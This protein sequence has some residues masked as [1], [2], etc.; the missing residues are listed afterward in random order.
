MAIPF[1]RSFPFDYGAPARLSGLVRRV[2]ARNPGPF[3]FTGTGVYLIGGADGVA[4]IDPGPDLPEHRAALLEALA[5]QTVCAVL[6]THLHLDHS[7]L[8]RPLADHFGAPLYG[9]PYATAPQ[10]ADVTME[11]GEDAAFR[12]D[13]VIADGQRVTGPDWT[14]RAFFTPGHTSNHVCYLLE[15]ENA[16]F[17]GDHVMGWST[18]VVSPPDGDMDAYLTSLDAV[19]AAGFDRLYPTHGAPI[20]EPAPFLAAYRA[21][22][23]AREA[24][25]LA[26][27]EAGDRTIPEM[28]RILYADVNPGLHPAAC[29]SV[30]AHMIALERRGAVRAE[31]PAGV[32][33]GWTL[34]GG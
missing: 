23:M 28:V 17:S 14:L 6:V 7:P 30:L 12:P 11:E 20:E 15:E 24:Q 22:R 4:I 32:G 33:A 1:I 21:H 25:I 3:T 5:G 9:L 26:R 31:G 18:T 10:A 8:A 2:I 16:L 19:A 34:T 13:I 29:H 27:L